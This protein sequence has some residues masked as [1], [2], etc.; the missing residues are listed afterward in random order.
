MTRIDASVNSVADAITFFFF[1]VIEML[2]VTVKQ[3]YN[4]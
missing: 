3:E 4:G 2:H 1:V